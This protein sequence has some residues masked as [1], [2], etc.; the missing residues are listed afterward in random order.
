MN[1]DIPEVV[2]V[3]GNRTLFLIPRGAAK[4]TRPSLYI[5]AMF[6]YGLA[7]VKEEAELDGAAGRSA[8]GWLLSARTVCSTWT[9]TLLDQQ[10]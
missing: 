2:S 5:G 8:A 3:D 9:D 10:R 7:V 1:L 6:R 4:L